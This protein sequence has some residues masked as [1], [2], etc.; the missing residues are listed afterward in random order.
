ME[1][2]DKITFEEYFQSVQTAFR[3]VISVCV[4]LRWM[5][6]H[7]FEMPTDADLKEMVA[8][9]N[10]ELCKAWV[11]IYVSALLEWRDGQ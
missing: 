5:I 7:D 10:R 3:G 11:D 8:E 9:V 2:S 6:E 1:H 4:A